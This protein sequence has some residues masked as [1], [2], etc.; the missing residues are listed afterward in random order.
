MELMQLKYFCEV[1]E[2]QHMTRSARKLHIAQPALSQSIHRL[3]AELGVQL[4]AHKG[5][6]ICLTAEG[7]RL[8]GRIRPL[9]DGLDEAVCEAKASAGSCVPVIRVG[10]FAASGLVVDAIADFMGSEPEVAFEVVQSDVNARYDVAVRTE[11]AFRLRRGV[12]ADGH[13]VARF[14]EPI[15]VAIPADRPFGEA[16]GLEDLAHERFIS[17]AGSRSFRHLCD[18]LCAKRGFSPQIAFDSDSPAIVKKMIGLG[19]GV[20]FWPE[21]SWGPVASEEVRWARIRDREFVRVLCVERSGKT[22]GSKGDAIDRFYGH[23]VE[24]IERAFTAA[25]GSEVSDHG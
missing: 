8:K 7:M 21:F 10:I 12:R 15:G 24:K 16:V 3:E 2:S 23:V 4:F 13:D 11:S 20:G 25:P 1:A 17:L 9:L 18:E 14:A 19:L 6:N 5:R 22:D